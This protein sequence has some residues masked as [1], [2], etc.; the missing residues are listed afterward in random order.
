MG[1][2]IPG[3]KTTAGTFPIRTVLEKDLFGGDD[4]GAV[5]TG[6]D[7]LCMSWFGAAR[8]DLG[9]GGASVATVSWRS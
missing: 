9:A 5:G 2:S 1:L 4:L 7:V 6:L 3:R 8:W